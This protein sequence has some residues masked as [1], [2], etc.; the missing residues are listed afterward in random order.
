MHTFFSLVLK[1]NTPKVKYPLRAL[2]TKYATLVL[3]RAQLLNIFTNSSHVKIEMYRKV[4]FYMSVNL[5]SSMKVKSNII[6]FV[7]YIIVPWN[8]LHVS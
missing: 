5:E 8:S 3:I 1:F 7:D 4:A 2:I 6:L